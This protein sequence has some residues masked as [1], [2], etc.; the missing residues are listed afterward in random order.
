MPYTFE[1]RVG[2]LIEAELASTLTPE[3]AQAFRTK[4]YLTLSRIEGRAVLLGDLRRCEMF[5]AD[6]S[7]RLITMLKT[8]T[9]KVERTAFLVREGPFANQVERMVA[10]ATKAATVEGRPAPPRRSFRERDRLSA[11]DWL[12]EVLTEPERARLFEIFRGK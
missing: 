6:V 8:D 7:D 10:A 12:S 11:R 1:N 4:M 3:E 5:S 2:R 9:P